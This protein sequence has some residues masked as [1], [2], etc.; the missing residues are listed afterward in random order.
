MDVMNVQPDF[1]SWRLHDAV[2][3]SVRFDWKDR[4]CV[5]ALVAFLEEGRDAQP[6]ELLFAGYG[7]ASPANSPG[8]LPREWQTETDGTF[9]IET[10]SGDEI[11]VTARS[12][13]L[14][15]K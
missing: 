11:R 7:H 3:D 12:A 10:Q 2:L 1:A 15:R 4:A 9:V 8:F 6:C 5:I 14:V 13:H